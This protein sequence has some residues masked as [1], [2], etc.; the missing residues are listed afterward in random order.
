[1]AGFQ[2]PRRGSV[3]KD[4]ENLKG[5]AGGGEGTKPVIRHH[6]DAFSG[7]YKAFLSVTQ[8][9]L[10]CW[11]LLT[12]AVL[13]APRRSS[14]QNAAA[15][16]SQQQHIY[17]LHI[18]RSGS[19]STS[20][21][22][23]AV[24]IS[25]GPGSPVSSSASSSRRLSGAHSRVSR[26]SSLATSN[27]FAYDEPLHSPSG[28]GAEQQQASFSPSW[29]AAGPSPSPAEGPS[30]ASANN[31]VH[32]HQPPPAGAVAATGALA[33]SNSTSTSTSTARH[34][35]SSSN[36]SASYSPVT[37]H[38]AV[39]RGN[40]GAMR[41]SYVAGSRPPFNASSST[42]S[43]PAGTPNGGPAGPGPSSTSTSGASSASAYLNGMTAAAMA[44][45]SAS[46]TASNLSSMRTP[47]AN[48]PPLI[49]SNSSPGAIPQASGLMMSPQLHPSPVGRVRQM[50][51]G[52]VAGSSSFPLGASASSSNSN[53]APISSLNGGQW[54]LV[55]GDE[56]YP[57]G[58][59]TAPAPQLPRFSSGRGFGSPSR[60]GH[61]QQA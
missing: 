21:S 58:A 33:G 44:S 17:D 23:S 1:M 3:V 31:S 26:T 61:S 52:V 22:A 6:A 57:A 16:A 40:S 35:F 60:H 29:P 32:Q 49:S 50:S 12:G 30:T 27:A 4:K 48:P 47:F 59:S 15:P 10:K 54:E 8:V 46:S 38:P 25:P 41:S 42:A 9:A 51:N 14:M 5:G 13:V 19:P 45:S 36:G 39:T 28:V 2:S 18:A 20:S 11:I 34:P 53:S 24:A 56:A 7:K 55:S 37:G 43:L